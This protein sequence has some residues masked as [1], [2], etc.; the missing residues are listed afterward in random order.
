MRTKNDRD[1]GCHPLSTEK[2][3]MVSHARAVPPPCVKKRRVEV[4]LLHRMPRT[5]DSLRHAPQVHPADAVRPRRAV[6]EV[7]AVDVD[8]RGYSTHLVSLVQS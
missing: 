5:Q 2:E 1:L 3:L 6:V 7:E 8:S 4:H